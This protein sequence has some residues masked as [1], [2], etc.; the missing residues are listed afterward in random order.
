M[1]F[2]VVQRGIYFIPEQP[3]GASSSIQFLDFAKGTVRT[4]MRIEK[5]L[6]LGLSVSPDERYI[7]YTQ[8]EQAGSDLMLVEN[9]R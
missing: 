5:P 8:N 6:G 7:L 1:N 3:A 2:T 4:I 9:F